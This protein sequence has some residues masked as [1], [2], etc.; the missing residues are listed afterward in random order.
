LRIAD[1]EKHAKEDQRD[2]QNV[3][4]PQPVEPLKDEEK[5]A[6]KFAHE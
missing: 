5:V 1:K 3:D 2:Q 6:K 4:R